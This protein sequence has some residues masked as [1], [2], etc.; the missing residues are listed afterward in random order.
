MKLTARK[1]R[2]QEVARIHCAVGL[3]G[4]DYRMKLIYKE[5]YFA[6]C[7]LYLF[8]NGFQTLFKFAAEFCTGDERTHIKRENLAVF[9]IFGNIAA[10]YT[11]SKPFGNSC[12][13]YAG[14][15]YETR[16]IL[17]LT[18]K[19]TDDISY[20][21]I[22]AYHRIELLSAGKSHEVLTV[23]L[24]DIVFALGIVR[25]NAD[26]SA[27]LTQCRTEFFTLDTVVAEELLYKFARL[28]HHAEYDMLDGNIA[29][30]HRVRFLF[31]LGKSGSKRGIH[32]ETITAARH[33]GHGSYFLF[34]LTYHARD[35]GAAF[36]EKIR[37][38]AFLLRNES[39]EQ[40][41]LG[42][43]LVCIGERFI[44]RCLQCFYTFLSEFLHVHKNTFF[45]LRLCR[46]RKS[47]ADK[48]VRVYFTYCGFCIL[49]IVNAAEIFFHR[50]VKN[51]DIIRNY[52]ICGNPVFSLVI[53]L[54]EK[55]VAFYFVFDIAE[56][57]LFNLYPRAVKALNACDKGFVLRAHG[58]AK[59][60]YAFI[61]RGLVQLNT[62][63]HRGIVFICECRTQIQHRIGRRRKYLKFIAYAE[64]V[65][66]TLENLAETHFRRLV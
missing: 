18:R 15:A 27:D 43:I 64:N 62:V 24:E 7:R 10:D 35:V 17:C 41:L 46:K 4:T 52:F 58:N 42:E 63:A 38:N 22:S 53:N 11:Q 57:F 13:T 51:L 5:D 1:H 3:A 6:L 60:T 9:Q 20:L 12:F 28:V 21:V 2:L 45:T 50:L 47:T 65:F 32:I 34:C 26:I 19:Y 49:G 16:I 30:V 66:D 40:M 23:F 39:I 33:L 59:L 55:S 36:C 25:I 61:A 48:V 31:S 8:K 14:F 29:V 44:L 56:I 54:A 37:Y